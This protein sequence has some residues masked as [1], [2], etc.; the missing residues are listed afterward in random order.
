MTISDA[1]NRIDTLFCDLDGTLISEGSTAFPHRLIAYLDRFKRL[2]LSIIFVS[3]RPYAEIEP[4]VTSLPAGFAAKIVYE[5]GAYQLRLGQNKPNKPEFLLG[6]DD[7]EQ[8]AAITRS[9]FLIWQRS[10]EEMY[11]AQGVR[12]GWAGTG[13][14][15]IV[16]SVDVFAGHVPDNYLSLIGRQRDALKLR[17][18][19]LLE[20]IKAELELFANTHCPGWQVIS[21]GN[22][23]FEIAPP[24]V[25][26]NKAILQTPEFQRASGVLILGDSGN[27]QQMFTLKDETK[28]RTGLVLHN[29]AVASL[30]SE[31]DFVTFGLANPYPLFDILLSVI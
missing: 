18:G 12:F 26:K 11:K 6:S 14:Q 19:G 16:L 23:N 8:Q 2:G 4:L 1:L 13:T 3:G 31:V 27:D 30:V 28:T 25:E 10:T 7:I 22:G 5:K 9:D 24:D 20:T 15:K 29:P 21:L 17:D